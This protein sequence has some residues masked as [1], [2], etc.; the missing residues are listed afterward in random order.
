[1]GLMAG[2]E[3][4]ETSSDR[5]MIKCGRGTP[6]APRTLSPILSVARPFFAPYK[7]QTAPQRPQH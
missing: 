4:D 3:E 7:Q 2:S 1:M 5:K 6:A